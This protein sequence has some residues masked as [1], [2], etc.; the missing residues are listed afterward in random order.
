MM[1]MTRNVL[2]LEGVRETGSGTWSLIQASDL[3][4]VSSWPSLLCVYAVI[5]VPV[6]DPELPTH[7]LSPEHTEVS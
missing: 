2:D 4:P 7:C 3:H 1:H 5:S 6:C